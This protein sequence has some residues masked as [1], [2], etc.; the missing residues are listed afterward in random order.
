MTRSL[1]GTDSGPPAL[2]TSTLPLGYRGGG[3]KGCDSYFRVNFSS[4]KVGTNDTATLHLNV[5]GQLY[6]NGLQLIR[7]D[8][9]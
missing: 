3:I 6:T 8:I 2:E 7:H 9:Q 1:T 5:L 4:L